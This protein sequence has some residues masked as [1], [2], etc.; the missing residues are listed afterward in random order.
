MLVQDCLHRRE[1]YAL[2]GEKFL[3]LLSWFGFASLTLVAQGVKKKIVAEKK[4]RCTFFVAKK[5]EKDYLKFFLI[6]QR[7]NFLPGLRES[8][9]KMSYA[10]AWRQNYF[11]LVLQ[12]ISFLD[13]GRPCSWFFTYPQRCQ[14]YQHLWITLFVTI[15]SFLIRLSRP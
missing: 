10:S 5:F 2:R 6:L 1:F 13:P 3:A 8:T 15:W 4:F 12:Q 14:G 7:E 9:R 11:Q